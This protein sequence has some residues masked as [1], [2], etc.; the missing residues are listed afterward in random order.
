LVL[1]ICH[2][3]TLVL[4]PGVSQNWQSATKTKTIEALGRPNLM[5]KWTMDDYLGLLNE[6]ETRPGGVVYWS[7]SPHMEQK[8]VGSN[9]ARV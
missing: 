1:K 4:C 6:N 7:E 9:P 3:A 5:Q 2:L 8:I